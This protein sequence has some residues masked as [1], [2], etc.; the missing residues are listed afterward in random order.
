MKLIKTL[1]ILL[2]LAYNT[3][4]QYLN[5]GISSNLNYPLIGAKN[6]DFSG[7][8]LYNFGA[9]LSKPVSPY[10]AN[11]ILNHLDFMVESS[12]N[13]IGFREVQSDNRYTNTYLDAAA[14]IYYVPDRNSNDLKLFVGL[15]PSVLINNRSEIID[16]GV[17]REVVNDPDNY[18]KNGDVDLSLTTGIN[19]SLGD[20][21]HAE[22][23]YVH[24][25]TDYNKINYIKGRP[26]TI[27]FGLRFSAIDIRNKITNTEK[28]T[29]KEVEK[30]SKGTLLVMLPTISDKEKAAILIKGNNDDLIMFENDIQIAN[31]N[32]IKAFNEN[33]GFCKYL[34]FMDSNAYK[35]NSG[36]FKNI[37][38]NDNFT[39]LENIAFDS[40][41]Y[42][43]ASFCDDIS[44]LTHKVSYGLY[45]YD[46]K[47]VQ[48][49]KPFLDSDNYIG[50]YG[51]GDPLNYLRKRKYIYAKTDY[52][53][54]L[55]QFNNRLIKAKLFLN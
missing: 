29:A 35:V 15:R 38:I 21:V 52:G 49:P 34:F 40:T 11:R 7:R 28:S 36:N 9:F 18:N 48:L 1:T 47:F 20:I 17:Y 23:K 25:L 6:I 19:V 46:K 5:Y 50:L 3:R 45:I 42:F 4:A 12:I 26:S 22:L 2:L 54:I 33:F 31:K 41:N 37:F 8:G 43:I 16:F 14:S 39:S 51:A 27:E 53:K 44:A 55:K 30:L 10:H 32:I 24:S 13:F